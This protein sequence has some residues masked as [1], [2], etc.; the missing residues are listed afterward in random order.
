MITIIVA[1]HH[2]HYDSLALW[3][4]LQIGLVN[5]IVKTKEVYYKNL[6]CKKNQIEYTECRMQMLVLEITACNMELSEKKSKQSHTRN[7]NK[8]ILF[9]RFFWLNER[10]RE[11]EIWKIFFI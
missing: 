10:E 3:L 1:N 6:N 9:E 8:E 5:R 4:F 7:T 11:R 2:H